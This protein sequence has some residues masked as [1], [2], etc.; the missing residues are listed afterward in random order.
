MEGALAPPSSRAMRRDFLTIPHPHLI[1]AREMPSA[2]PLI[3]ALGDSLVAGYGLAPADGF[4]T[5]L[6]HR[7]RPA[8]PDVRVAN[9]GVSGDTTGDVARRL[10]YVLAGLDVRPA[11]AIVQ[12][13]PNDVLRQVPPAST[14]M[15]LDAI[16]TELGRCAIPVL[17]TTVAMPAFLRD[18][19][20]PYLGIHEALAAR[21]GATICPFFPA[22]V[23]GHP[24]MVLFDRVHPNA[25]AICLVVDAMRPLIETLLRETCED[26]ITRRRQDMA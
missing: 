10:P 22:D 8:W 26:R 1:S 6:E 12:V 23:L 9:A 25:R 5:Q 15:Q 20:V 24:D 2:N 11:L 4:P 13:G 17:L 16:L 21:H 19:A 14:R 18:R 3:L 7:L